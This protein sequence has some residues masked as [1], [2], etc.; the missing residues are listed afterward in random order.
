MT[1]T[2]RDRWVDEEDFAVVG[3]PITAQ[4]SEGARQFLSW[5]VLSGDI[6]IEWT[7]H[8]MLHS[9]GRIYEDVVIRSRELDPQSIANEVFAYL[10][11]F[12][13][14]TPAQAKGIAV[15]K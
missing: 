4:D 11:D 9:D 1:A 2:K 12:P 8:L 14:T 7:R 15:H 13:L 10:P 5:K 6:S 3:V